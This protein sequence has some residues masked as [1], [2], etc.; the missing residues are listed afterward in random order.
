MKGRIIGYEEGIYKKGKGRVR[1]W[2]KRWKM[3]K[4]G[5]IHVTIIYCK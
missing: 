2:V 3:I 1:R 4:I 5:Y